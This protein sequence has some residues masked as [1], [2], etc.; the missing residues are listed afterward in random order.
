MG[1]IKPLIPKGLALYYDTLN[2]IYIFS[3]Y[4]ELVKTCKTKLNKF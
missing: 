4:G 1:L 2:K 3:I